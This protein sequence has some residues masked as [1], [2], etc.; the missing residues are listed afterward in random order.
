MR[1]QDG[2]IA[3]LLLS[4]LL[5][6]LLIS[7]LAWAQPPP[8]AP[9]SKAPPT[10]KNES[11]AERLNTLYNQGVAAAKAEDWPKAR[12]AF[13]EALRLEP[14]HY[15]IAANLGRAEFMMGMH[16]AAA[17]HLSF[18]LRTAP[19]NV[20]PEERKKAQEMF[21]KALTR[22]GSLTINVNVQG[23]EILVGGKLVG[24][25]PLVEPIYVEP[26]RVTVEAKRQG[27]ASLSTSVDATAGSSNTLPLELLPES[28][29]TPAAASKWKP[30]A[31]GISAGVAVAGTATGIGF[32]LGA[33]GEVDKYEAQKA[34][35]SARTTEGFKICRPDSS[36]NKA[37]CAAMEDA[38]SKRATYQTVANVGYV[39]AGVAAATA[40]TF[41]FWPSQPKK[42]SGGA[43]V[44]PAVSASHGGLH[45]IG[46]F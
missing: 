28:S 5:Q 13:A 19:S 44:I 12:E 23:A 21:D 34:V 3:P 46:A 39:V 31:I 26:G 33:K 6:T 1:L 18:F 24:Q 8:N 15:Q 25:S 9:A 40:V 29:R 2:S 32:W 30:W 42:Q 17:D 35:A 11:T 10:S 16:R 27:Y 4:I 41:V 14:R 43:I 45:V 7:P 20:N 38:R 22:V 37:E 36:L